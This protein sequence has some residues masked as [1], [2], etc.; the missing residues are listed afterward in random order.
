MLSILL[1]CRPAEE[2][3]ARTNKNFHPVDNGSREV[4]LGLFCGSKGGEYTWVGLVEILRLFALEE[5]L[6]LMRQPQFDKD[7]IPYSAK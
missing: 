5:N 3:T 2:Y 6:F 7:E 1:Q 4:Y